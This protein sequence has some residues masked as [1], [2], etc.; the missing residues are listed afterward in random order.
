VASES[1][2]QKADRYLTESR[3]AVVLVTETKGVFAVAGS[4][5]TPYTVEYVGEWLCNCPART[6]VCA[7]IKACQKIAKFDKSRKALWQDPEDDITKF[8]NGILEG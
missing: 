1:T 2:D 4:D 5:D 6:L 7:H 3:V 8:L